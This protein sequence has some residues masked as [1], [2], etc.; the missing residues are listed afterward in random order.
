[1]IPLL[2]AG[3]AAPIIQELM[4]KGLTALAGA[5]ANKGKE[6]VE[7]KLGIK[8]DEK[9]TPERALELKQIE[10]DNEDKLR[11]WALENRKL[12][13]EEEK[14]A[15][16]AV[17]DRWNADLHSD[18][19]LSKNIRPGTLIYLLLATTLLAILDS[20]P[21]WGLQIKPVWVSLF[22]DAL[23]LVLGAYFLGRSVEKG[24]TVWQDYKTKREASNGTMG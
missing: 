21:A 3:V 2:A 20:V 14:I 10:L 22:A 18:N 12:D 7:D 19:K 17:T 4:S 1:M 15:Q 23:Q 24:V 13:I 5:V 11:A 9:I 6:F 8:L 16:G